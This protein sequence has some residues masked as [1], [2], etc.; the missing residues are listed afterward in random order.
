MVLFLYMTMYSHD[1][2]PCTV[3]EGLMMSMR[4]SQTM[5]DD[6]LLSAKI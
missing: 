5:D 2:L 1:P 3:N 4:C 6:H